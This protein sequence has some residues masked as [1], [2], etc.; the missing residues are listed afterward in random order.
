MKITQ[1]TNQLVIQR[2]KKDSK[3]YG[4]FHARGE[5]GLLHYLKKHLNKLGNN[6]IKK[7][8]NK[9]GHLV[10]DYQQYLRSRRGQSIMIW[11]PKFQIT[12]LEV[13]WNAGRPVTL[14]TQTEPPHCIKIK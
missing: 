11:S 14:M 9:D 12:G 7:R 1:F 13:D 5:S 10:S 4:V 6:L 3:F 8:M 2:E